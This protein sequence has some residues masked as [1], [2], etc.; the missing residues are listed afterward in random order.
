M[1]RPR[2]IRDII[3]IAG[4]ARPEQ[5]EPGPAIGPPRRFLSV[6]FR[7]CHTYGRMYK[8]RE[9]TAYVGFCPKCGCRVQALIGPDGTSRRLFEAR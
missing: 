3:D 5:Q 4:L 9:A 6:W 8:N 2:D 1:A 7:C